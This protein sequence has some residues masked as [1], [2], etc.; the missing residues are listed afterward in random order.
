MATEKV[1]FLVLDR[2]D[3]VTISTSREE[4]KKRLGKQLR[5]KTSGYRLFGIV[6]KEIDGRDL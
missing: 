4:V 5:S 3:N 1:I 2:R 6:G